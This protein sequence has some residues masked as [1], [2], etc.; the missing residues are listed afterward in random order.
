MSI[1]NAIISK[2]SEY[3]NEPFPFLTDAPTSNLGVKDTLSYVDLISNIFG[4]SIVLSKDLSENIQDLKKND[5]IPS[6]FNFT[7]INIDE[8]KKSSLEN[9]YTKIEKI[10]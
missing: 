1:I 4:Q 9:T 6:I 2:S 3:K 5:K 10:K 8:T 7:T